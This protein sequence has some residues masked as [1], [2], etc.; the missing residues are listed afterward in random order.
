MTRWQPGYARI[1][2][3]IKVKYLPR[4][5]DWKQLWM[6]EIEAIISQLVQLGLEHIK[7]TECRFVR[8][9]SHTCV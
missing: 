3:I 8:R 2:Y 7:R 6:G 5:S 9:L 1:E 4:V